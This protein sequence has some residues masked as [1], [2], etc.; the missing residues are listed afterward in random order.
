MYL[1]CPCAILSIYTNE[2]DKLHQ[3]FQH[4]FEKLL[5][6]IL[7]LHSPLSNKV[8]FVLLITHCKYTVLWIRGKIIEIVGI[9]ETLHKQ[10]NVYTDSP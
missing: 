7:I 6:Q 10:R 9:P 4:H 5:V 8:C 2:G 3:T 1:L